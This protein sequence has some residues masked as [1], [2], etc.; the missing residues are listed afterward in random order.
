M[1]RVIAMP[2]EINE[3]V[4]QE[5]H[6]TYGGHDR[7]QHM[8]HHLD[9]ADPVEI[10]VFLIQS[11]IYEEIETNN[12]KGLSVPAS[13]VVTSFI[14]KYRIR[15]EVATVQLMIRRLEDAASYRRSWGRDFRRRWLLSWGSVDKVPTMTASEIAGQVTNTIINIMSTTHNQNGQ[16]C[17]SRKGGM[18]T[19][20]CGLILI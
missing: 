17:L 2:T 8:P 4:L 20:H 12:N 14:R 1:N 15:P 9:D 11:L 6:M 13:S 3:T 10:D 7:V 16:T 18:T 19:I 5:W